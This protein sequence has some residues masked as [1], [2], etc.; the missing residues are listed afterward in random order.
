M[1]FPKI[2]ATNLPSQCF[3]VVWFC[4]LHT[5]TACCATPLYLGMPCDCQ[6][7]QMDT[8]PVLNVAFSCPSSFHYFSW[9]SNTVIS[10]TILRPPVS[11][12]HGKPLEDVRLGEEK[13]GGQ[14]QCGTR[15]VSS[16]ASVDSSQV[17]R[18]HDSNPS[19]YLTNLMRDHW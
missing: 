12:N 8:V 3:S 19:C 18:P 13:E 6:C 16:E 14:E 17:E 9:K 7:S 4:H 5:E 15:S 2:V 10:M 1:H 11:E